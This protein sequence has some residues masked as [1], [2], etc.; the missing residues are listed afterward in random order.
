MSGFNIATILDKKDRTLPKPINNRPGF[1]LKYAVSYIGNYIHIDGKR[2]DEL[3]DN[4]KLF[5]NL[6]I[7]KQD[8][9]LV[10]WA[11][12]VRI[13]LQNLLNAGKFS[14]YHRLCLFASYGKGKFV[15]F[16]YYRP[17]IHKSHMAICFDCW[18]LIKID[19]VNPKKIFHFTRQRY[20]D[21][22]E[23]K[24][25]MQEHWDHECNKPKTNFG[26]AR[27]IQIAYRNYKNRPESLATQA[28][29]A[30]RD[31]GTSN[32]K[33]FLGLTSHEVKNPQTREQFNQWRTKWIEI[34]KNDY[35]MRS[36]II[37][38][39]YEEYY[40]PVNWISS[41]KSQLQVRFRK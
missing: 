34:Y 32:D 39:Q 8:M 20:V 31:D 36:S 17:R 12:R 38:R 4:E 30:M 16:D 5:D 2:Y 15:N 14:V 3:F 24:D 6:S 26:K 1:D 29:N 9:T 35:M 40:I 37:I 21:C 13:P 25:L 19:N 18:K 27:I 22:L 11:M 41:K 23:S 10:Q 7:I 28:W 33:K